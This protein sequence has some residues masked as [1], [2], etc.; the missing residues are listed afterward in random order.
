[1]RMS[2]ADQPLTNEQDEAV[3]ASEADANSHFHVGSP[4]RSISA[5][6]RGI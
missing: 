5:G 1:L 6:E 2:K 3:V 4:Q